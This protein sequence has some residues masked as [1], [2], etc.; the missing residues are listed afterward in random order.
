MNMY[1]IA[2]VDPGTT[3][4]LAVLDL[5]GAVVETIS[6]KDLSLDKVIDFLITHGRVSLVAVDVSKTPGFVGKLSA[7]IGSIIY[8]PPE[9]LSVREKIMLTREYTTSDAHQRDALA[10]ALNAF[11]Q[12]N[13][14][15]SKID[16]MKLTRDKKD[17]IKDKVLRG[18]SIDSAL[19]SITVKKTKKHVKKEK[20]IS[21]GKKNK[22]VK[23]KAYLKMKEINS[24]LI[25][26]NKTLKEDK[27]ILEKK[28]I[29]WRKKYM[30]RLWRDREIN[31]RNNYIDGLELRVNELKR[32]LNNQL[33]LR[34]T[35]KLVADGRLKPVGVYPEVYGGYTFFKNKPKIKQLD[36][37][38][39]LI[40]LSFV[41][42]L[43]DYDFLRLHGLRL[44]D[45]RYL[46]R[47]SGLYFIET[48]LLG[49][50]EVLEPVLRLEDIVEDYRVGRS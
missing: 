1:L 4:G 7:Q 26:E 8:S 2:G 46:K 48:S 33:E 16:S 9:S 17:K 44:S 6:S 11:N 29:N 18:E 45:S 27:K 28:N 5:D 43:K 24:L 35:L 10:A 39:D 50:L 13:Q 32:E 25:V 20:T 36:G 30:S 3:T 49:D 23:N 19:K 15:F 34:K 47:V 37:L 42:E 12:F 14:V 40:K 38:R 31:T 21:S 41:D 22:P